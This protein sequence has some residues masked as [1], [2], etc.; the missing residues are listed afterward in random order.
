M[1]LKALIIFIPLSDSSKNPII[2]AKDS[3]DWVACCFNRLTILLI[4]NPETGITSN[5]N[6]V[7][8]S[9]MEIKTATKKISWSG[10]LKTTC[11]VLV[12]VN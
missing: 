8:F 2:L 4:I 11:K 5:E 3:C 1:A 7:N 10:S 6:N 9:E 12:T